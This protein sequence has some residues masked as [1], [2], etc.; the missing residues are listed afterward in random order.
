MVFKVLRQS[1]IPWGV[2]GRERR[3]D[4]PMALSVSRE[5]GGKQDSWWPRCP[6]RKMLLG[7][8]MSSGIKQAESGK[9][10][11]GR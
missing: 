2:E 10:R 4:G 5:A 11:A 9:V 8:G 6:G 3:A 7:G 1:E